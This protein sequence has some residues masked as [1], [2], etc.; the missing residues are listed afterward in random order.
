MDTA[1]AN[2]GVLMQT[3]NHWIWIIGTGIDGRAALHLLQ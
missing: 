3:V 2:P 1:P